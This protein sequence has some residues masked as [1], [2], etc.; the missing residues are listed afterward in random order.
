MRLGR[1][2]KS[3][4]WKKRIVYTTMTTESQFQQVFPG[5][6]TIAEEDEEFV[7]GFDRGYKSYHTF[8]LQGEIIETST[9][10]FLLKNGWNAGTS[11]MWNT[12]YIMGWLKGFYEQEDR[13]RVRSTYICGRSDGEE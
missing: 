2:R 6:V 8:H 12:G 11:D 13:Q 4:R 10:L 5:T 1:E 9:F 3:D 7:N